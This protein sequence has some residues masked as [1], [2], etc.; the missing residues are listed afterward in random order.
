MPVAW[1]PERRWEFIDRWGADG[2]PGCR[3]VERAAHS[4]QIN[5]DIRTA[6][7]TDS[8]LDGI[9]RFRPHVGSL[10]RSHGGVSASKDIDEYRCGVVATVDASLRPVLKPNASPNLVVLNACG[11]KPLGSRR[12]SRGP[13]SNGSRNGRRY[14]DAILYAPSLRTSIADGHSVNSAQMAGNPAVARRQGYEPP[15]LVAAVDV[16]PVV[17]KVK[18][19]DGDEAA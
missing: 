11:A 18:W 4:E 8:L 2:E 19:P 13:R 5:L 12:D 17:V 14:T 15:R 1:Q 3:S 16:K 6:A 9:D 7:T 10:Q